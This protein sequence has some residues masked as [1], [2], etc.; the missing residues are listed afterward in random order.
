VRGGR[1]QTPFGETSEALFLNSSYTYSTAEEGEGRFD[2]SIEG[3]K[4]GRYSH[5]NLAMLESRL[6]LMEG[7]E[8]CIVTSSG[9]S[10]MFASLMCQLKSGDHV[11]AGKVL[12]SSCH[13]IITEILPR[14][15]I[16]Y[17]LVDGNDMAAWGKAITKKT[18]CVF[19]ETPAN[20]PLELV[21]IAAVAKLCK[22]TGSVLIV[23]NVFATPML[24]HPL[25]LGADV[26][27]YSTTKHIDGQGRTLGGA[28]LGSKDFIENTLLPFVR[29]TG[30][31]MSPFNA[32][33]LLKSLETLPLRVERHCDNAQAL[34]TLLDKE[35]KVTKLIY[36]G[37]KSHPQHAI[38]KKQM[39]RGGPMIAFELKGGKKA[40][41]AFMNALSV[42]DISNNLG[43]AKSLITHPASTTH[44][45]IGAA[46]RKTQGISDGLLRLSV[47]I[48]DIDDLKKDILSALKA[49]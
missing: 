17:T 3:F 15:G 19:I 45:S 37:L 41:F 48:E 44:A 34:A 49:V 5:P 27:M 6:A 33:V 30:P 46:Q 23:D 31:H 1:L 7:A 22:K 13:Y 28:V 20:P 25:A 16:T 24:Q 9:M 8:S 39:S 18:R 38:A 11:V 26:V 21:D 12:F 43:N 32:W 29:H 10:A 2:G 36:P 47:G 40:A 4:Y 42:I 35:A 14:F